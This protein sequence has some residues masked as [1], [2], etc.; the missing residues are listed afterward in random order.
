[1]KA[2]VLIPVKSLDAAKSRLANKLSKYQRVT[3]ITL[4]LRHIILTILSY[5]PNI[6][7]FV[8]SKDTNILKLA[9]SLKV[10]SILEKNTGHNIALK[11]AAQQLNQSLPIL[12]ISADIPFLTKDD[13]KNMF[14]L[15]KTFNCVLAS[16]KEKTGTNAIL[17][18][19]PLTIPYLFGKNSYEKFKTEIGKK[20]LSYTTYRND[21]ISFDLDTNADY[22]Y[23]KETLN[24]KNILLQKYYK[25]VVL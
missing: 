6:S 7:V 19:K 4:M 18:K 20:N 1:M 10:H 9:A 22:I 12:T 17:L 21:T 3:L 8:V 13:L 25:K 5:D 2:S 24:T 11:D 16:A 15:L 14:T 23:F